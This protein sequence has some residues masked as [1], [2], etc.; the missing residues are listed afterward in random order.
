MAAALDDQPFGRA[1]RTSRPRSKP[2]TERPEPVPMPLALKAMAK[3]G[4]R[5]CSLSRERDQ[6]DDAGVPF[7]AGGDD[8]GRP[9]ADGE[10]VIGLGARL[11]Q[12]LLL[13]R[14]ALLVQPVE[15]LGDAAGLD[16]IV[17]RQQPAAERGIADAAAGIDARTDQEAEME[18]VD[19]LADARAARQ[20]GK[21]GILL[22]A[23]RQQP[24]H[25]EGAVDAGER[26]DV[27]DRRQRHEIEQAEQI[28]RVGSGRAARS[29]RT[30]CT[31]ARKVTPAAHRWPWPER[32]SSRFGLTTATASGSAPPTW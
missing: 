15:R 28:G 6:A 24:L 27:A 20:R 32:S 2:E 19:R 14:L 9:V 21:A 5:A 11:G 18:G 23:D 10:F 17:G 3:A 25:D 26:H 29:S 1:A 13:H 30:V 31:R 16:R 12:H 8:D 22:P 7:V 4:R